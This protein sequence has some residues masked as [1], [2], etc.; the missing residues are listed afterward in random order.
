VRLQDPLPL[1]HVPAA[2]G[3][4]AYVSARGIGSSNWAGER[5]QR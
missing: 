2:T 5:T 4:E 3:A 1:A